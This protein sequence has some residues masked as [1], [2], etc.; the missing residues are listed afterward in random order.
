MIDTQEPTGWQPKMF[1]EYQEAYMR[2]LAALPVESKC[3]CGWYLRGECPHCRPDAG[4]YERCGDVATV[5]LKCSRPRG[6]EGDHWGWPENHVV[7]GSL[8]YWS[9]GTRLMSQP[10]DPPA[11][12]AAPEGTA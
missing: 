12:E 1:N 9:Q 6:H 2:D 5:C 8:S 3:G 7:G 11:S 10:P 4:G